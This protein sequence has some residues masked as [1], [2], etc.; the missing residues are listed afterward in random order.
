MGNVGNR[1]RLRTERPAAELIERF[2]GASPPDL[3]DAMNKTGA[4]RNVVP[5]YHPIARCVGPAVTVMVPAGGSAMILK[6][7]ELA[8][9]GDVIVIDGRGAIGASLWGG[10]RSAYAAHKGVAGGG[11]GWGEGEG[12]VTPGM[13]V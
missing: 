7:M 1:V 5:M 8:Q 3:A 6:A 2:R 13:E 4:M 11:V 9:A 10:N 12:C